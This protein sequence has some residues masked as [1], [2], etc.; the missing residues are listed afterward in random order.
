MSLD[1]FRVVCVIRQP[2]LAGGSRLKKRPR[3]IDIRFRHFDFDGTEPI[4]GETVR[5]SQ[6]FAAECHGNACGL[7]EPA[8]L[9]RLDLA[10]GHKHATI[11]RYYLIILALLNR[12]IT[13]R[14]DGAS[15]VH[16]IKRIQ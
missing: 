5:F 9:L 11:H 6:G 8:N 15:S 3:A 4:D 2:E 12:R 7:Q 13:C 10:A 16:S 1:L 14:C